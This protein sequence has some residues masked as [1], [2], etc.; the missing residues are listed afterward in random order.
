MNYR[1]DALRGILFILC[2]GLA[3]MV[4]SSCSTIDEFLFGC[5]IRQPV[6]KQVE[7]KPVEPTV[8]DL[9]YC[10]VNYDYPLSQVTN[11]QIYVSKNERRLWLIQDK[12]L[13][14]DYHVGLGPS[15]KGDKYLRGDGRTPEGE[16][17]I[18][19]KKNPSRYYKSLG[20]NYPS[21]RHAENGLSSGMITENDY[22]QIVKANDAKRMPPA[23][24]PLGGLIY[25]HGGGCHMDWTLGCVAL[26]NSA[27]DELFDVVKIGTPVYIIP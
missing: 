22:R 13:V 2:A 17:F 20:I 12:I 16:Y 19:E 7:V 14:R 9:P 8:T 26:P 23:N 10:T 11:P 3:C 5:Q 21:P 27:V 25:I 18:C 4:L 24:T 1:G 15:P 6:I